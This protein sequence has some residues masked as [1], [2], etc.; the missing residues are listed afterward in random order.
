MKFKQKVLSYA[1]IGTLIAIG[2]SPIA[3]AELTGLN[4]GL[5]GG[6]SL[7]STASTSSYA[8]GGTANYRLP[9]MNLQVGAEYLN[10]G[11]SPQLT[12]KLDYYLIYSFYVGAL[13]GVKLTD[14]STVIWGAESAISY[15]IG[16]GFELGPKV[17]INIGNV[18]GT[19]SVLMNVLAL[20]RYNI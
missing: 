14:P 18:A 11:E 4:F 5:L 20:L 6:A 12:G 13:A 7:N 15:D 17:E 9:F 2:I 8:W 16:S 1:F 19:S 3:K 10:I